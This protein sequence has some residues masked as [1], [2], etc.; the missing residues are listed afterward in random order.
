MFEVFFRETDVKKRHE[1]FGSYYGRISLTI[2]NLVTFFR[3]LG[4][5][6][7][8]KRDKNNSSFEF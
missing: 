2:Q 7:R 1:G 8:K 4:I 5:W 6:I 3:S